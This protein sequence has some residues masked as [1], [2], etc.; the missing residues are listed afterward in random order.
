LA[1]DFRQSNVAAQAR[2]P[3]SIHGLYRRLIALRRSRPALLTGMYGHMQAAGEVLLYER[4]RLL[5]ALNMG[6]ERNVTEL[7]DGYRAGTLILSSHLD[8][9][10]ERI[11][12]WLELRAD[13]GVIIDIGGP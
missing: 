5:I 10:A 7:A 1:A 6:H 12:A 8:R 4:E 2:D 9:E 13:E 11:D 3:T